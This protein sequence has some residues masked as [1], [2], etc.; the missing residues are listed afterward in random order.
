MPA[1]CSK[2]NIIFLDNKHK[3][4][5]LSRQKLS[6]FQKMVLNKGLLVLHCQDV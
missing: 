2:G 1:L 6:F 5:L 3:Y 4:P